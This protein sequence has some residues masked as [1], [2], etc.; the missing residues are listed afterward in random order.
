MNKFF[1]LFSVI[2][3]VL[4]SLFC[5]KAIVGELKYDD[6][7]TDDPPIQERI[8]DNQNFVIKN[9]KGSFK[10]I[11]FADYSIIAKVVSVKSYSRKWESSL[12]PVDLALVWGELVNKKMEDY[13]KYSQRGRWYYYR[14]KAGCPVDNNYII[15]HS[16][17]NHI[18]PAS[19]NLKSALKQIRAGD[20]VKIRGALVRIEGSTARGNVFWNSST[21]R[22]DTGGGSCEIIYAEIIRINNNLYR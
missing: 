9:K 13:I 7:N 19:D 22:D 11:P 4:F 5:N 1:R 16:S 17:N 3:L 14:Y 21:R 8:D 2:L 6:L 10:I 20:I 18:I 12:S 15:S